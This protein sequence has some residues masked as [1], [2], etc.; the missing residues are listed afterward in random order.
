[1]GLVGK[2]LLAGW[3]ATTTGIGVHMGHGF[4][5]WAYEDKTTVGI[6]IAE[7]F[8]NDIKNGW[9]SNPEN[10]RIR[11]YPESTEEGCGG[12]LLGGLMGLGL[13]LLIYAGL[14]GDDYQGGGEELIDNHRDT[15]SIPGQH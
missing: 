3:L 10:Y 15:S 1:M 14:R 9:R 8:K 13:G 2:L 5:D 12:R 4:D 11:K 6:Q 7:N